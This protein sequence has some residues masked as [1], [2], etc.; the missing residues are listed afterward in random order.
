[1]KASDPMSRR[2][3]LLPAMV[4]VVL[5]SVYVGASLSQADWEPTLL[6]A[7]GE[8][9][10][11]VREY[12]EARLGEVHL[13]QALGHDGKFFFVQA[14]DPWMIDPGTHAAVLD[15]P[16]YR[17]QRMLYP[18]LAG[19][20]GLFTPGVIVW[21]MIVVNILA[22]GAGTWSTALVA[23]RMGANEWWGLAFVLNP[24]FLSEIN[25]GGAGVVAGAAAFTAVAL[26]QRERLGWAVAA[27][28]GAVLAREAMLLVAFGVAFWLWRFHGE[29]ARAVLSA[30]IP[31]AAAVLWG[32][33]LRLR[34]G[35]E[36]GT[37][38]VQEIGLPFVG[39]FRAAQMWLEGDTMSLIVG[40]TILLVL[41]AF[42]VRTVF[43]DRLIG[44]GFV[45]FVVLGVVFTAQVW[46]SYFDITRAL[47]PATTAYVLLAFAARSA[48]AEANALPE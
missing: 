37:E 35:W 24:G 29:K 18:V 13:R 32:L 25:I 36:A 1:M 30:S 28:S 15:R 4:A 14:N 23:S 16:L 40:V 11:A 43:S 31:L 8:D 7:F 46:L 2:V 39:F 33:Y 21:A 45:G 41:L 48:V 22:M 10:T 6:T 17:A 34:I 42:A 44:W 38:Q 47:A 12:G 27:L 20:G 26:I 3:L 5:V 9:S 19:G